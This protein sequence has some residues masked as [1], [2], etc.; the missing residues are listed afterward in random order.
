[1][2]ITFSNIDNRKQKKKNFINIM[3]SYL[4]PHIQIVKKKKYVYIKND[5]FNCSI[6]IRDA[7]VRSDWVPVRL[8]TGPTEYPVPTG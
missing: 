8:G 1:M 3:P 7:P 5:Y 4:L 6:L 2:E